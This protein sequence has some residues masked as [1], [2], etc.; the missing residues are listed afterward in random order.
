MG[1]REA[2]STGGMGQCEKQKGEGLKV[3]RQV[4]CD[5]KHET[6]KGEGL[7]VKGQ[8][9]CNSKHKT[10]NG[11]GLEVKGLVEC[12]SKHKTQKGEGLEVKGQ[13]EPKSA[14]RTPLPWILIIC[15]I[16]GY[17]HSFRITCDVCSECS[18]AENS[19]I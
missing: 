7:E 8:V 2:E 1:Q 12:N 16:K 3:K 6:Q 11:E 4:E 17:S 18:R 15:T 19:A 9:E 13:V 14:T 5:S 10:Q